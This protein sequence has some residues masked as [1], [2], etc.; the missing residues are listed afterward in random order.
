MTYTHQKLANSSGTWRCHVASRSL[1]DSGFYIVT[2][3]GSH[4]FV[5]AVCLPGSIVLEP[6]LHV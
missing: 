3:G 2:H 1:T 6:G 5:M 4:I